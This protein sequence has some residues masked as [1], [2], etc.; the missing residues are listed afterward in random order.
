MNKNAIAVYI[1]NNQSIEE[2]SWLYKTWRM[3]DIS[4]TWD[5]IAF[6]DPGAMEAITKSYTNIDCL[7]IIELEATQSCSSITIFESEE[8]VKLLLGYDF[9][10]KTSCDT[11]LTKEF[12]A[13]KPWK[14]KIYVG[15]GLHA[16]QGAV[17]GLIREKEEL[18]NKALELKWHGHTHI[19][20][21]LIGHSSI[22]FKI[23]KMQY[24]INNWLLKFSFTEGV[25]VFPNWNT[26]SAIDY[27][28]EMAINHVASPLS[29]HIGSL[30][31]WC[32]SNEL[33][34][35]D[36]SIKTWSNNEILFNKEKWFAGELPNIG[37]SKLP[38]TAGEYCLMVA[39]SNV[40]QLV[41]IATRELN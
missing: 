18:L 3:W 40:D 29:L 9:I 38:K 41:N 33:T 26:N 24:T 16:N 37:F 15:I 39:D 23:T 2:F 30:D 4:K 31:T 35:L 14:D 8:N 17:G 5:I 12:S 21:G 1:N 22:V 7:K 27:A 28:F 10:Y 13:F 25:G 19:G 6:T 20:G 32:S 34:S 11:F 36:L